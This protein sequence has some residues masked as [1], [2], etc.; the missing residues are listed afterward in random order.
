MTILRKNMDIEESRTKKAALNSAVAIGSQVVSLV[1]SFILPRL[2]LTHFGS[3]YN[4]ITSSISQFIEC[5]VLLRAGI[6]GVTRAAL[7]K[8]L[9]EGNNDQI[10]GI[11]NATQNFMKKVAYLFA[12]GLFVLACVYPFAVRDEFEWFFSFSLVLILGISTFAQNYF[13]ITYQILIQADQRNYIY[14]LISILTTV[15]NTLVASALILFGCSIHVVKLGSA[16]VFSLNPVLLNIYVKKR[17]RINRKVKPNTQA[18]SQRWDAFAQQVAAFVNNNTDLVVLT[19]FTNLK[20]VS[21]YTV[22]Y[23]IANRLKTLVLTLTN[24]IEASFGNIIAKGESEILQNSFKVYELLIFSV[25]TFVFTCTMILIEPFI[26]VYTSGVNDVNY[27]RVFFGVLMSINQYL[28]CIRLPYQMLTDAVGHFKQTRNGAIFEAIMNIV[29]SIALVIKFGIIGV[30]I[31]TFCALTFRT[32]QYAI[33]S[34]RVVLKRKIVVFLR[35]LAVSIGEGLVIC[36]IIFIVKKMNIIPPVNS[37]INWGIFAI[38][39]AIVSFGVIMLG[40]LLL[41]KKDFYELVRK[42]K[43]IIKK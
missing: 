22:Y 16:I 18:I 7:Y 17:Y 43:G 10:S 34:S 29:L 14:S 15:L 8:P 35:Q 4:G 27:S 13:G 2:I 32:F 38:I 5:V 20:E 30:T 9:A 28:F 1:C 31:G 33:Y 39:T 42:L 37:Y 36:S 25:S 3:A 11:V 23:M 12:A 21:V 40:S 6:G 26:A 41:Y 19:L 24:G